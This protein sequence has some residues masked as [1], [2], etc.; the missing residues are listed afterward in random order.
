MCYDSLK[1][2]AEGDVPTSGA[3]KSSSSKKP[4]KDSK[5]AKDP[6]YQAVMRELESQQRRPNGFANHPKMEKLKML[7]IQHFASGGADVRPDG[8]DVPTGDNDKTRVMVFV[9]FR[10]CVEQIV[11]FLNQEKPLLRVAKFIGQGTDKD[12]NRGFAQKE[13]LDV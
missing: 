8:S 12:G 4:K 9:T 13:Q 11:E 3:A 6:G 7:V 10:N 5:M 2:L 1:A